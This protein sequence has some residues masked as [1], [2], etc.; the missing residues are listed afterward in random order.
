MKRSTSWLSDP[1]AAAPVLWSS[2]PATLVDGSWTDEAIG[3]GVVKPDGIETTQDSPADIT[4]ESAR[5]TAGIDDHPDAL[6]RPD[7]PI[8]VL[9][10]IPT[11][12]SRSSI[13]AATNS[14]APA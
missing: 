11:D 12:S 13:E 5:G 7:A 9:S 3:A 4:L 14:F 10:E 2:E 8:L 6:P 1:A